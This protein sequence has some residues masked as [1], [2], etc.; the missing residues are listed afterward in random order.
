MLDGR[1]KTLHP[2]LH[3]G[4][5][6]D[7]SKPEHMAALA[8]HDITAIDLVVSNLYPF[9]S[10]PSIELIDIGGP[11][12]VRA[13]AK[14]HEHVGV[15]TSPSQYPRSSKRSKR[16][17]RCPTRRVTRSRA[18]PSPTPRP[19]TRR[20]SLA[21]RRR[22]ASARHRAD[23]DASSPRPCTSRWSAPTSCATARTRTRSARATAS[24]ARRPW[25]DGVTQHAGS[26]LSYLN[27]FDADAAWRLVHE[28]PL[29]VP[30]L[31]C[32]AIIKHANASGAAVGATFADA[33]QGARRRRPERLRR[34]RR[35]GWRTGRRAGLAHRR[36]SPGRRHHRL[37]DPP[38]AV[39]ILVKRRKATRLSLSAVAGAARPLG[40]DL[41]GHRVGAERGRTAGAGERV[42]VRHVA[43][44][45]EQQLQDLAIAWRVCARTTSNAIVIARDGVAVGVGAGQQSRVV[46]AGIATTKAG[47]FANGAA[48]ASDA[49]FPFA[50]GLESLTS[51]GV[52]A[53]VQPG[54]SVRDQEVIDAANAAEIVMMLTGERHFRH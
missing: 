26:A 22:R 39:D 51:A 4:I 3:A 1:V 21:R 35:G 27:L 37:L 33:F 5:L 46:A 25:W 2:R 32:V 9:A 14:N 19:T 7:R 12:M 52:T 24:P 50:D 15:L 42:A 10:D 11:S 38:D 49:F 53:V 44:P 48:A 23:V 18:R 8:E 16:P 31:C 29:D 20:S 30:G 34:H 40:A 28:L 6:A 17:A 45:T 13:A 47:E 36:R 54:G 41:R 43:T